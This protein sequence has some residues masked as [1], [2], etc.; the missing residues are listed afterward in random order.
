MADRLF[1]IVYMSRNKLPGTPEEVQA[2]VDVI[3]ATSRRN[4]LPAGV[5]GVLMFNNGCFLQVLEGAYSAVSQT[6]ERIQRDERHDQVVVLDAGHP[7]EPLFKDWSMAFVGLD[8][9]NLKRYRALALDYSKAATL[10][11]DAVLGQ[12]RQ[13]CTSEEKRTASEVLPLM[14]A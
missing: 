5:T 8:Q 12:L 13:L 6:F 9:D 10:A 3:L 2:Q 1:R 4:N 14:A 11:N 7:D